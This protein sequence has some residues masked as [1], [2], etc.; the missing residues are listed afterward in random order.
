MEIAEI[1]R[2]LAQ[3]AHAKPLVLRVHVFGSRA[4]GTQRDDSDLDVAVELDL[5]SVPVVDESVGFSIWMFQT[6]GW[7]EE[8]EL[9]IPHRVQLEYYQRKETPTIDRGVQESGILVYEKAPQ[10]I[11]CADVVG[12]RADS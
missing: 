4:R 1:H 6:K 7:K 11:A 8:L 12:Q 5:G 3:W 9:L 2:V 10:P